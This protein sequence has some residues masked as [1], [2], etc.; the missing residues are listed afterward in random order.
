M[1][2]NEGGAK[3]SAVEPPASTNKILSDALTEQP[4][5]SSTDENERTPTEKKEV[6]EIVSKQNGEVVL[7]NGQTDGE[8]TAPP[9][10]TKKGDENEEDAENTKRK[11][12]LKERAAE[13]IAKI[14]DEESEESD[15][16]P[17][18][19]YDTSLIT[20][21]T[22]R[23]PLDQ[24]RTK[25]NR[26]LYQT[27]LYT[28]LLEDRLQSLEKDVIT[29]KGV[30]EED[31]SP[32]KKEITTESELKISY[33]K[34]A[35]FEPKPIKDV[36]DQWVHEQ[37]DRD[38]Y[39]SVLQVL[40]EEP[41]VASRRK[42]RSRRFGPQFPGA[43]PGPSAASNTVD[44]QSTV[45]GSTVS[46]HSDSKA[47]IPVRLRIKSPLLLK[48]LGKCCDYAFGG[49][50][51][52]RAVILRPFKPFVLKKLEIETKLQEL[53]EKHGKKEETAKPSDDKSSDPQ[54]K[55]SEPENL[56]VAGPEQETDTYEALEVMRLLDRFIKQD[57]KPMW[58]LRQKIEDGTLEQIAFHDLWHL[59]R[60]GQHVRTPNSNNLQV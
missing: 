17:Q 57:L 31:V 36:F 29:L 23:K 45:L 54:Q 15:N 38:N 5:N 60:L 14:I 37:R 49:V 55:S 46:G 20:Y 35:E 9:A 41:V 53:E 28:T 26:R 56:P 42:F 13:V 3:E 10:T 4:S 18:L 1:A 39:R 12:R 8:Q 24:R 58:D 30:K 2:V 34:W 33:L 19:E 25:A 48:I 47:P 51:G 22:L 6:T 32:A 52:V 7:E 27:V 11:A 59:F 16:D 50:D 43:F 40:V 44:V 21:E